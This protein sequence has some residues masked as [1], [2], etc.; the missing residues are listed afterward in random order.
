MNG[1]RMP[2][3]RALFYLAMFG[4]FCAVMLGLGAFGLAVW[5]I[6]NHV[7]IVL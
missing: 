4:L 5:F 7:R 6:I 3:L 2:D 1:W